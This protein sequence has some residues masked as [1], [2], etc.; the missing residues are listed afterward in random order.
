MRLA[1]WSVSSSVLLYGEL[2]TDTRTWPDE[3]QVV[4][5]KNVKHLLPTNK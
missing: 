2:R 5:S 3:I 1:I 4:T